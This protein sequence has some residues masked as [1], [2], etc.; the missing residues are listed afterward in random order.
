[1]EKAFD[2]EAPKTPLAKLLLLVSMLHKGG[3]ISATERNALKSLIVANDENLLCALEVFELE[4]DF[5][6]LADTFRHI[7]SIAGA[8]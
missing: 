1:M 3:K 5:D 6:E 7:V 4:K 8:V 2:R